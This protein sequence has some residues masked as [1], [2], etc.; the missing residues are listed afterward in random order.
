MCFRKNS[1]DY[2]EMVLQSPNP[3]DP[4][5]RLLPARAIQRAS[6]REKELYRRYGVTPKWNTPASSILSTLQAPAWAEALAVQCSSTCFIPTLWRWGCIPPTPGRGLSSLIRSKSLGI[7][8]TRT[9]WTLKPV[10]NNGPVPFLSTSSVPPPTVGHT[11][12]CVL[13]LPFLH[14]NGILRPTLRLS[15]LLFRSVGPS[16]YPLKLSP[17]AH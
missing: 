10:R 2:L 17:P 13:W 6:R 12:R 11:T 3:H 14:L 5:S 4:E 7:F 1:Q 9:R 16:I 8:Q 15:L